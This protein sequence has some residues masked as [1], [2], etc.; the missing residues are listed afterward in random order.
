M[1]G[2]NLSR[3]NLGGRGGQGFKKKNNNRR[4]KASTKKTLVNFSFYIDSAKQSSNDENT[5]LFV[6]NHI[7][8]DFDRGTLQKLEY[9]NTDHWN[10]IFKSYKQLDNCVK[11]RE[12]R[13]LEIQFK[14][15][16]GES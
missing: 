5:A 10:P 3:K 9:K 4:R 14:V 12:D 7:K 16:Y 15:D 2:I 8:K 1:P 13:L 6:I 11:G